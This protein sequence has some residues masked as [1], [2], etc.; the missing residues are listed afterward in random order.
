MATKGTFEC[1]YHSCNWENIAAIRLEY[2]TAEYVL[3]MEKIKGHVTVQ[4]IN[5]SMEMWWPYLT[6]SAAF[7]TRI[8]PSLGHYLL[9]K[10]NTKQSQYSN[11]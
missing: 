2:F 4:N 11:Y 8:D 9:S 1:P 3:Q 10:Q 6:F 7:E 5:N